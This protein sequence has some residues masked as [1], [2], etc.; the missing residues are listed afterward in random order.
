MWCDGRRERCGD[1][2]R[3]LLSFFLGGDRN[4]WVVIGCRVRDGDWSVFWVYRFGA[5]LSGDMGNRLA[6]YPS[7]TTT[8]Y[9]CFATDCVM[10]LGFAK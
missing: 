10:V 3:Y 2:T 9:R 7:M 4:W 1:S 5:S 6:A 8:F